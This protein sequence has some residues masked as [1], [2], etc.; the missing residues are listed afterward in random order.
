MLN[1]GDRILPIRRELQ[2]KKMTMLE[3]VKM[4]KNGGSINFL[5][6]CG[7]SKGKPTMSSKW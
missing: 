5:K 4:T 2:H 3:I 1:C 6:M 7:I